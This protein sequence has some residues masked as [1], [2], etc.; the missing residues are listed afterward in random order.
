MVWIADLDGR[1][2]TPFSPWLG[3][4]VARLV[5]VTQTLNFDTFSLDSLYL[6]WTEF[7]KKISKQ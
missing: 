1:L 5:K 2:L 3:P 6:S 7:L 4:I